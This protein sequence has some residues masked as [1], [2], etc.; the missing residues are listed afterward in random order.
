MGPK[1]TW[2]AWRQRES[3]RFTW[4][5]PEFSLLHWND[6]R[7]ALFRDQE[8]DSPCPLGRARGLDEVNSLVRIGPK[9]PSFH[10]V[11]RPAVRFMGQ[12]TFDDVKEFWSRMIVLVAYR[13]GRQ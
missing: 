6:D 10:H 2:R 3:Q 9:G 5:S 1:L 11:R 13:T 7:L 4:K 12:R 8:I